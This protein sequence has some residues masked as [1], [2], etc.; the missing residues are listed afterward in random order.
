MNKRYLILGLIFSL[1]SLGI[2]AGEKRQVLESLFKQCPEYRISVHDEITVALATG[3]AAEIQRCPALAK[4]PI[5]KY[6]RCVGRDLDKVPGLDIYKGIFR[7]DYTPETLGS[8]SRILT[9]CKYE[10][11]TKL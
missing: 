8:I 3:K 10:K 6:Q 1:S 11:G 4:L 2:I 5:S 9:S 7:V